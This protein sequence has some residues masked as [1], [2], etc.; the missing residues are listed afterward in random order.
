MKSH[1]LVTVERVVALAAAD[2]YPAPRPAFT[3]SAPRPAL[4]KSRP[5]SALIVSS[6]C[7]V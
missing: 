2:A 6:P 3:M 7:S 1:L 4:T 5:A